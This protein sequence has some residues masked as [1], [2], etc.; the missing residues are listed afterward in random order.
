MLRIL[1]EERDRKSIK[2][3]EPGDLLYGIFLQK[4]QRKAPVKSEQHGCL[5]KNLGMVTIIDM[6]TWMVGS[7]WGFFFYLN[8]E[9]T[10][11]YRRGEILFLREESHP[12][13]LEIYYQVVNYEI[14][15]RQ[16]TL[17]RLN[18]SCVSCVV[19]LSVGK[20]LPIL[21]PALWLVW[22]FFVKFFIYYKE[23]LVWV[24]WGLDLS[25]FLKTNV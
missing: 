4:C 6:I 10:K 24:E 12:P 21:F 7:S 17:H 14:I 1:A 16:I 22:I 2:S 20:R 8:L 23:K 3:G 25:V 15:H 13:R 18:R 19:N 9:S 5:N 11:E